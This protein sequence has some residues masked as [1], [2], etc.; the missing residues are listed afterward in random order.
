MAQEVNISV[1]IPFVVRVSHFFCS[2]GLAFFVHFIHSDSLH[3]ADVDFSFCVGRWTTYIFLLLLFHFFVIRFISYRGRHC[4]LR[5]LS[6]SSSVICVSVSHLQIA[7][8][9]PNWV[10]VCARWLISFPLQF[11]NSRSLKRGPHKLIEHCVQ[12]NALASNSTYNSI[13]S[14]CE[15][16]ISAY[17]ANENLK[18]IAIDAHA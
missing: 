7:E 9:C 6:L 13:T 12:W 17:P 14:M 3:W 15:V 18:L 11:S 10:C 2:L 1:C 4:T 5:V 16:T 8:M